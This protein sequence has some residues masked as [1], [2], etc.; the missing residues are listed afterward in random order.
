[1]GLF[2]STVDQMYT[3][4]VRPQEYGN[5]SDTRWAALTDERGTGLLVAGR[6]RFDFAARRFRVRDIAAARHTVDLVDAGAVILSID[7]AQHGIGSASC[8]PGPLEPY[9][10]RAA[11]FRFGM[12]LR[13]FDTNGSAPSRLARN[14]F[15]ADFSP[16]SGQQFME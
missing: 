4:Y 2:H 7:Y 12:A 16:H 1:M 9:E 6:P 8:G 11:P 3:P 15:L 13:G 10:L 5:R 14:L